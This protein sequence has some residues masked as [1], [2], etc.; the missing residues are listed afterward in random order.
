MASPEHLGQRLREL[1]SLHELT[2]QELADLAG[3]SKSLVSKVEGGQRPGSL[4]LA[5]AVGRALQIELPVL[6][7]SEEE[8]PSAAG[9]AGAVLPELRR[10]VAVYDCPPELD[11]PLRPLPELAQEVARAGQLRLQAQYRALGEML[12][13]LLEELGVAAQSLVGRDREL[14]YWL[15]SSAYRCADAIVHKLGHQDLSTVL[16][17]RVRWAAEH[18]GDE[19]MIATAAYVRAESFFVAGPVT[20]GL[21]IL[22][23]AGEN[24]ARLASTD[25]QAASVYGALHARAAVLAAFGGQAD[26]AWS[27]LEIATLMADMVGADVA[28]FHT[29]FGPASVKVHEVAIAVELGDA[30]EAVR[31]AHGWQPPASLTAERASHHF[32]DLARAQTWQGDYKGALASLL[33]A[34]R[35]AP[36]H[37]RSHPGAREAATAIIHRSRRPSDAARGLATW[38]GIAV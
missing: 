31:R 9:W 26:D 15:L 13:P 12:V 3:V 7:G 27:H 20:S 33:E 11:R 25:P 21:R 35:R 17:D 4:N 30:D 28:Y 16:I 36:Q 1:R 5:M 14:A 6:L 8:A 10:L 19:L 2:Q 37:T 23:R 24:I 32:I 38:L 34:R 18:S 22:D 29:S